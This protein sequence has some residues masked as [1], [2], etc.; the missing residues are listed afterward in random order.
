VRL[1]LAGLLTTVVPTI[2]G[3][4]LV[5]AHAL[6]RLGL[7]AILGIAILGI[8]TMLGGLAGSAWA[9]AVVSMLAALGLSFSIR[10]STDGVEGAR[11]P[12]V[13]L[14][15]VLAVGAF[16]MIAAW[17]RPVSKF[18]GWA[19]WSLKAKAIATTGDFSSPIFTEPEYEYSHRDYPP[20]LP[21]WQALA[22]KAS[23]DL[24]NGA[25]TQFQLAWLWTAA[26]VALVALAGRRRT[27]TGFALL[28]WVLAPQV[29]EESLSGYA[30]VPMAL[31]LVL[32]VFALLRSERLGL[33][34]GA[35]LIGAAAVTKGEGL[36]FAIAALVPLVVAAEYRK[37]AL[38]A[39][40]AIVLAF[41][42]WVAFTSS[43]GLTGDVTRPPLEAGH[44]DPDRD[45]IER[46]P[47]VVEELGYR[48]TKVTDWGVLVPMSL[49]AAAA[50]RFRPRAVVAGAVLA[51][52][53]WVAV[54]LATP[55]EVDW[56]LATS[57]DRV[58]IAPLGL[59]AL[60]AGAGCTFGQSNHPQNG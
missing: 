31:F 17:S 53:A 50:V 34:P 2:V 8:G 18:D 26:G 11:P 30:D 45:P 15:V 55:F 12:I 4:R 29:V 38:V 40:G 14:L 10:H 48:A 22:Y 7:G 41:G 6:A 49:V 44:I 57:A 27:V 56:H 25:P 43:H 37:R 47:T 42:P 1:L 35:I 23:G 60:A 33:W 52:G 36:V 24:T 46:V 9:G 51:F 28:A 21:A 39:A 58:L 3:Y 32:G 19:F 59:L 20:L 54:Y 5:R 16:L 13:P